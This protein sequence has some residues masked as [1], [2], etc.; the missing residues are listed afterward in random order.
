MNCR[1]LIPKK[2]EE[3]YS[4]INR[5]TEVQFWPQALVEL[6]Q[7]LQVKGH[8]LQQDCFPFMDILRFNNSLEQVKE[9]R[10]VLFITTV[11]KGYKSGTA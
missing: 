4:Y 11:Y 2:Y 6:A 7:T 1:P 8:S 9:A 3:L 10:K 5:W